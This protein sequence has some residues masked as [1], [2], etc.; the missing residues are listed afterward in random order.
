MSGPNRVLLL[1]MLSLASGL[2]IYAQHEDRPLPPS[3]IEARRARQRAE[4]DLAEDNAR[5]TPRRPDWKKARSDADR[6]LA[7]AQQVHEQVQTNSEQ[8]PA[9]LPGKLAQI[10]GLAKRIKKELLD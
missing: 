5:P 9:T 7:L 1:M 2:A 3:L 6:L 10:E 8:L 4:Q